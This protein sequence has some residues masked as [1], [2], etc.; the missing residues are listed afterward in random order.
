[1]ENSM[2]TNGGS[3]AGFRNQACVDGVKNEARRGWTDREEAFLLATLK[4]LVAIGW[5]SDNGFRSGYLHKLEDSLRQ[6]FPWSDLKANPHL[7][8]KIHI[9]KKAYG[10]LSL[11]LARS[12]VGFNVHNDY[13]I[14]CDEEQWDQIIKVER[15]YHSMLGKAPPY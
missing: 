7:Q 15:A 4:K 3:Q 5:K 12:G 11:V 14:D 2:R 10:A 6:E 1:M 9:W 13:K 8:S